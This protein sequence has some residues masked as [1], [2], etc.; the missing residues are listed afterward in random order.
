MNHSLI[1]AL[2]LASTVCL[3]A[4]LRD[5]REFM[6]QGQPVKAAAVLDQLIAQQPEDPW[7]QYNAGVTAYAANDFTKADGIWQ[8][9][10]AR[11][12]PDKLRDQVWMQMGNVSF[13]FGEQTEAKA[14]EQALPQW[15]Q[16]REAYRV[17]LS[18]RPKDKVAANN[19]RVVEQKLAK[20][21]ARL[22]QRLVAEA[23]K[24]RSDENAIRK[25][26]AALDHQ[27]TAQHLEPDDE[28]IRKETKETEQFLAEKYAKKATQAE[29][30]ADDALEK[31]DSNQWERR[32]AEENLTRA[33]ADFAQ[34]K[35]LDQENQEAT[36]GEPRVQDKLAKLLA[37]QAKKL[38][39]EGKQEAPYAA[40]QAIEK[41]E[42][43]LDKFEESLNLK[44]DQ[45]DTQQAQ[46][47][48][49]KD[50]EQL[51]EQQGDRLAQRGQENVQRRPA[52]AA[53]QMMAALSHYE[54]AR[55]LNPENQGLQPK[56][57]ALTKQ[58]P[59]LLNALGEREQQRAA[60]AEAKSLQQAVAHLEKASTSY[61]MAQEISPENQ[62]AR[63][64]AEKAQSELT[65]LREQLAKK[66]Q[67][68]A[69]KQPPQKDQVNQ[70][71]QQMLA[72][73]KSDDK[74]KLYEER[75]RSPT[76]KYNPDEK[77]I[78]KNW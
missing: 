42:R 58:L 41:M 61:E 15:E 52:D 53:E 33:L 12:L 36:A 65:R 54:E 62:Q 73:A 55:D 66:A 47:E 24:E 74:Q 9:L 1:A 32:Q 71:F 57:D 56:M 31:P 5:A 44:T 23:R 43:S 18:A 28:Q 38:H 50:L 49:K 27:R 16:S 4:Q 67:Q 34:A 11:P 68:Q 77:R 20:L 51:L 25:L 46:A 35:S 63:Q 22:A 29:K 17:V 76:E 69:A 40:E 64:G 3:P 37:D 8:Q 2:L 45:P 21:H 30:R 59:E 19:L 78:F 72:E 6:Q 13:R 7:L 75:R 10:A 48:A 60:Q 26:E 14:P 70:S 39:Q